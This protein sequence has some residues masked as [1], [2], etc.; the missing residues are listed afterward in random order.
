METVEQQLSFVTVAS[1]AR[2]QLLSSSA[3]VEN[4]LQNEMLSFTS[5]D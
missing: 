2:D 5:V 1:A 3:V 4:N